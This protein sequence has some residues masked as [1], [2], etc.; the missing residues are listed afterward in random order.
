LILLVLLSP[1]WMGCAPVSPDARVVTLRLAAISWNA[2]QGILQVETT[3]PEEDPYGTLGRIELSLLDPSG[4]ELLRGAYC[5]CPEVNPV[6]PGAFGLYRIGADGGCRAQE[7]VSAGIGADRPATSG[8]FTLMPGSE[9]SRKDGILTLKWV[10]RADEGLEPGVYRVRARAVPRHRSPPEWHVVARLDV[11][12]STR[13]ETVAEPAGGTATTAPASSSGLQRVL[14]TSEPAAGLRALPALVAK[15]ADA[16]GAERVRKELLQRLLHEKAFSAGRER[17][18]V[19]EVQRV[20][21]HLLL[22]PDLL[23]FRVVIPADLPAVR[24]LYLS[25]VEGREHE[26]SPPE[27]TGWALPK[28]DAARAVLSPDPWVVSA[29]LFLARKTALRLDLADLA[30]RRRGRGWD[31]ECSRQAILYMARLNAGALGDDGAALMARLAGTVEAVPEGVCL[32]QP[33]AFWVSSGRPAA[34]HWADPRIVPLDLVY[35]DNT[36]E[37]IGRRRVA[38]P[39]GDLLELP[40]SRNFLSL[41]AQDGHVEGH[42]RRIQPRG[43]RLLRLPV[44]LRGRV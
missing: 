22:E 18:T 15:G 6:P 5:A 38:F 2:H 41:E 40:P 44:A 29:A 35:R 30:T 8:G 25:V 31:A 20:Y 43:G 14:G 9:A 21:E 27:N 1:L 7:V 13:G 10:L 12:D 42:S 26:T 17:H 34:T 3:V 28:I 32:L 37:E 4:R 24:F 11:I 23:R 39:T 33:V 16:A 36:M 19:E